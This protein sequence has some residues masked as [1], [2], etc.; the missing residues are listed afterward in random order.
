MNTRVRLNTTDTLVDGNFRITTAT[1][2]LPE[3]APATSQGDFGV[4]C[5]GNP[6]ALSKL[7]PIDIDGM[8]KSYDD[9]ARYGLLTAAEAAELKARARRYSSGASEVST[10]AVGISTVQASIRAANKDKPR[11]ART[12]MA[13]IDRALRSVSEIGRR[14]AH[15][16]NFAKASKELWG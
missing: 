8:C 6:G 1:R 9:Q 16:E 11:T 2:I 4:R 10:N 13:S 7:T 5:V 3:R 14:T 15:G 12:G